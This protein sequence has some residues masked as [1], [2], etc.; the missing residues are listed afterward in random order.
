MNIMSVVWRIL[1]I[2]FL[3]DSE[4]DNGVEIGKLWNWTPQYQPKVPES[5]SKMKIFS[6]SLVF[7]GRGHTIKHLAPKLIGQ[8]TSDAR[9]KSSQNNS[10]YFSFKEWLVL[11]YAGMYHIH[12]TL[13]NYA[14]FINNRLAEWKW[15]FCNTFVWSNFPALTHLIS[16]QN[17]VVV[18]LRINFRENV[19]KVNKTQLGQVENVLKIAQ[20][21]AM[22]LSQCA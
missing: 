14:I 11:L 18:E 12:W 19:L 20:H 2:I 6:T 13:F 17:N 21:Y 16:S 15:I 7:F 1:Q 5:Y 10:V 22:S 3:C 8:H 9:L 4:Y